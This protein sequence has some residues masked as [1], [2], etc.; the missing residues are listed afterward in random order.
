[1]KLPTLVEVGMIAGALLL[2]VSAGGLIGA[3]IAAQK[4]SVR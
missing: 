2:L 1:M 4:K 3:G